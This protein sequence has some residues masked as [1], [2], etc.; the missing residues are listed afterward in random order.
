MSNKYR[1]EWLTQ[2]VVVTT[3]VVSVVLHRVWGVELSW[4]QLQLDR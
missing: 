2:L 3:P 1:S 4:Q